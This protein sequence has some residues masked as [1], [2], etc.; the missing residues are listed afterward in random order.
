VGVPTPI[1]VKT[2]ARSGA[3]IIIVASALALTGLS[4][5][6]GEGE[7][8]TEE[9][10]TEEASII[11]DSID[12]TGGS[13]GTVGTPEADEF[14]LADLTAIDHA[15]GSGGVE[16]CA[17]EPGVTT[18][19]ND[20]EAWDYRLDCREVG[21]G[22]DWVQFQAH[23]YT[24]SPLLNGAIDYVREVDSWILIWTHGRWLLTLSASA[25]PSLLQQMIA[26]MDSA[27]AELVIDKR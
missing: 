7:Q 2:T 11:T 16:I 14:Q 10:V 18:I 24:N 5:A 15:L 4:T 21:G 8:K 20:Y 25:P 12:Q 26:A 27:G 6:C 22:V 9:L 1:K 3:F 17:K 19:T 23:A 13:H